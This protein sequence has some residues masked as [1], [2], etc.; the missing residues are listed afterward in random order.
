MNDGTGAVAGAVAVAIVGGV[1]VPMALSRGI[2]YLDLIPAL[3]YGCVLSSLLVEGLAVAPLA[4]RLC[5]LQREP[6]GDGH[7]SDEGEE[8]PAENL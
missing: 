4:N 6:T 3:V 1:S 8:A 5:V 7:P 2:A